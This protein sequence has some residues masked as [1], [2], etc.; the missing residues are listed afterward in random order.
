MAIAARSG[1]FSSIVLFI[2]SLFFIIIG[3]ILTISIIFIFI[4]LP[5]LV[6]G[7]ILLLISIV[8]FFSGS[9]RAVFSIFRAPRQYPGRNN[10]RIEKKTRKKVKAKVIDVSEK[11]GVYKRD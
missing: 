9:L 8:S 5:L 2:I 1:L 7:V 11:E 4:G 3:A 10:A 6:L